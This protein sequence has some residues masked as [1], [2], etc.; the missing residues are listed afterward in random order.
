MTFAK[1]SVLVPTRHR[2]ER[3]KT[4]LES[5]TRTTLGQRVELV[6]RV[7]N[8]D[9]ETLEF[10]G[11][12]SAAYVIVSGPR[13]LGYESLPVFFNQMLAESS[14]DVLMCGNDDMVFR[15]PGWP[16]QVLDAANRYPD[17]LFNIGVS[18]H[19]EAHYP[20]SVTSRKVADQLGFLWDPRIFWGDI[21]LRDVMEALGHLLPLP[22]VQIDHDWAGTHPDQTFEEGNAQRFK[23]R[24]ASYWTGV[25]AVA[26][27][28]AVEKLRGL[29]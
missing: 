27:A 23:S 1:I 12:A 28:E 17:G 18:T 5:L 3:L 13:L 4:L 10:L 24:D 11:R 21:F 25:H 6:F 26:V 20:F 8:D 22:S 19:N 14:G 15:T 16:Q 2:I 29:Q 9:V 7:D